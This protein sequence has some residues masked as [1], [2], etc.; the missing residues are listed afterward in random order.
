[1]V[2]LAG[3]ADGNHD[4]VADDLGFLYIA[5]DVAAGYGFSGLGGRMEGPFC[6]PIQRRQVDTLCDIG[7]GSLL[8]SL[9]RTLN[10]VV[11]VGD[12]SG[13][14]LHG[15]GGAC[16]DNN[17]SSAQSSGLLVY[18]NGCAVAMHFDDFADESVFPNAYHVKHIGF[19]HS[20]GNDQRTGNFDDLSCNVNHIDRLTFPKAYAL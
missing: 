15:K 8:H 18:L 4:F 2:Y 17:V 3:Y 7:T 9:E 20:L 14:K 13:T 11:N 16:G 5:H 19:P 1:M 6:V 12:Q 10:A